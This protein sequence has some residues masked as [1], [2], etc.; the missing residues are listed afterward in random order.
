MTEMQT[1]NQN[2]NQLPPSLMPE[3]FIQKIILNDGTELLGSGGGTFDGEDLWLWIDEDMTYSRASELFENNPEATSKITIE[4]SKIDTRVYERYT[5]LASIQ[6]NYD[7]KTS[8][9]LNRPSVVMSG[10]E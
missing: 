6:K 7:N 4:L 2:P 5:I 1:Q 10:G 8:I 3:P 9:R